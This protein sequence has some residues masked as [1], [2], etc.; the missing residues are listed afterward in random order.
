M[1]SEAAATAFLVFTHATG[2]IAVAGCQQTASRLT[3]SFARDS[4]LVAS[5]KIA[6]ID[7]RWQVPV[8]ALY[9][10]GVMT[11]L[12][13]CV[14][15]GSSTAFNA[16]IG[17][18]LILQLVTF[19]FPAALLLLTGRPK[20]FLPPTRTFGLPSAFGW[21]ANVFTVAFALFCLVFYCFPPARPVTASNM[22]EFDI[23]SLFTDSKFLTDL[24]YAPAVLVVIGIFI[25]ANWFLHARKHYHG[26]QLEDLVAL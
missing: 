19:A 7:G 22:S 5:S 2:Y 24:D 21:V 3:W 4:G 10:N 13:G 14:Y 20:R 11:F 16:F 26:P 15:L 6:R 17:T 8:W 12:I 9:V 25:V 18:G 23:F 1:D